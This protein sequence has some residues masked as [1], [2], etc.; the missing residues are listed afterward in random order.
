[1]DPRFLHL[2]RS[3]RPLTDVVEEFVV[4]PTTRATRKGGFAR[5]NEQ[6]KKKREELA[7]SNSNGDGDSK[8][9]KKRDKQCRHVPLTLDEK[10]KRKECWGTIQQVLSS[11]NISMGDD[12]VVSVAAVDPSQSQPTTVVVG[13]NVDAVVQPLATIV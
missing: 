7:S 4:N 5:L 2:G 6:K 9:S 13:R 3:V 12:V 11:A 1:L 10:E 8:G